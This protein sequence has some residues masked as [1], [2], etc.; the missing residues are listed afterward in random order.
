M[1]L[2]YILHQFCILQNWSL[3]GVSVDNR[4]TCVPSVQPG[5]PLCLNSAPTTCPSL[6]KTARMWYQIENRPRKL[7]RTDHYHL[8]KR[9]LGDLEITSQGYIKLE[10]NIEF[11]QLNKT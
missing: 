2:H 7:F 11:Q 6:S 9:H 8:S 1:I 4:D 10:T 5:R 3:P